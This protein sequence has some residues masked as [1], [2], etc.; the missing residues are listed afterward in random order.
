M[1]LEENV[2]RYGDSY[3]TKTHTNE[4]QRLKMLAQTFDPMTRLQLKTRGLP[5]GGRCLDVGAG[6]GSISVWLSEQ[7]ELATGQI[8]ALDRDVRGLKELTEQ[9]SNI[10]VI[11][12]DLTTTMPDNLIGKFDLIH[13]RF[14]LMHLPERIIVLERLISCLKPGGV[15]MIS[16]SIDF[17]LETTSTSPYRKVMDACYSMLNVTFGL[18]IQWSR[19]MPHHFRQAGLQAIGAEVYFPSLDALSP[20]ARFWKLTWDQIY[21]QMV[22]QNYI[23]AVTL[24]QAERAFIDSNYWELSAGMLTAWGRRSL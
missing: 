10:Q 2:E 21:D 24:A 16:D 6:N 22:R 18:D 8:F 4:A 20:A 13:A 9:H 15:I 23:D 7:A 14:V 3:F 12:H 11:E 5:W 17:N 19:S 1:N